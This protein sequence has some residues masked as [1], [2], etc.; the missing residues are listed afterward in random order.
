M[1][2]IH[3]TSILVSIANLALLVGCS[4]DPGASGIPDFGNG[5]G[6]DLTGSSPD[7]PLPV[8][9]LE[10]ERG[11]PQTPVV[12]TATDAE[13]RNLALNQL[14]PL[15]SCDTPGPRAIRRLTGEQYMNT[16]AGVFGENNLP[17]DVPLQDAERLGY[18]VD[19]D[20][21]LVQGLTAAALNT[22]AEQLAQNVL[23]DGSRFA[24]LTGG[25]TSDDDA[26]RRQFVR[27]V[28]Q[29]ISREP[30]SEE[31]V[32]A[33][34]ALFGAERDG[35]TLA[36]NFNEGAEL[37][38]TAM[39]QSPYLLYRREIGEGSGGGEVEL[40]DFEI[41]SELSYFL[42]DDA[43]DDELLAAAAAGQLSTQTEIEAQADRLLRQPRAQQVLSRFFLQWLDVD[44]L[45]DK[46]KDGDLSPSLRSAML[47]ETRRLFLNALAQGGDVAE[48]FTA[49]YT[50]V[51]QELA[52][53]YGIGGVTSSEFERVDLAGSG[54]ASGLL[55][56]GSFLSEHALVDNSSP[57]QRAFVVRERFLCNDLPEPPQNLDTNLK[58]GS[59]A[60]TSRER[61]AAHSDNAVCFACHQLMDPIG[62]TFEHYDGFGLFRDTE[63]G[64][65]VDATGGVPVMEGADF[66][67]V[68]VPMDGV[69]E[70]SEYLSQN[71]AVRA[72][73]AGHLAYVAYGISDSLKWPNDTKVC[74]DHSIRQVAR[75]SGNTLSSVL[76][77]ILRAPHFTR[78]LAD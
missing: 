12:G 60:A 68:T 35:E 5:A 54:R 52:N 49:D 71:E 48:L 43:P 33:Y 14:P 22:A 65:P 4:S 64:R 76:A 55:G 1:S 13:G 28:G 23:T 9:D 63:A 78:R 3:R 32:A 67:G 34:A 72:C 31:R 62:F 46:A 10:I 37:V 15:E 51:N 77:G 75:D 57:V 38:I 18:S 17:G 70:L 42:T 59:P 66:L 25:C 7:T 19:A 41:A 56:H 26:C 47:E 45:Q 29:A 39:A 6:S 53:Y 24:Q 40:T 20:D 73:F 36:S 50:F 2:S 11:A 30:M 27:N 61:Y 69:Q 74:T 8:G 58:P 16:L 44:R 21:N